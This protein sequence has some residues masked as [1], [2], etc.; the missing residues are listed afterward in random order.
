MPADD[1]IF[2]FWS[3]CSPPRCV[4]SWDYFTAPVRA[5]QMSF[6][7]SYLRRCNQRT[8]HRGGIYARN[9]ITFGINN[10]ET[11][12]HSTQIMLQ[13]CL[14]GHIILG[15]TTSVKMMMSSNGYLFRVT[16]HLCGEFTGEFP[17]QRPVT[18]SFDVFFD[19]RLNKR[20]SKQ[21]C[22]FVLR[23]HRPHY[24]VIVMILQLM[25]GKDT[26]Y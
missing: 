6:L 19:L 5:P 26:L 14:H 4:N 3:I 21:W 17:A 24:D 1:A 11:S 25:S 8:S 23:R 13:V 20:L 2:W 22:A 10:A 15:F 12:S 18:R 9:A 7:I 16:G